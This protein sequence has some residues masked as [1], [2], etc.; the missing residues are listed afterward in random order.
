MVAEVRSGAA[1]L[2]ASGVGYTY[3]GRWTRSALVD[4]S[5]S[6]EA[7]QVL[8]LLGPNG[9]GKSTLFRIL[10][11]DEP[12]SA[13]DF[14]NQTR[15]LGEIRRAVDEGYLVVLS[16][17]NPQQ[18]LQYADRVLL[19]QGS[20]AAVELDARLSSSVFESFCDGYRPK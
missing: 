4:V 16:S 5:L 20:G 6:A 1:T 10:V 12:T 15:V 7:G 11:L 9:S 2:C 18:A 14:G 19:H 3:R 13:L 17:H 8:F